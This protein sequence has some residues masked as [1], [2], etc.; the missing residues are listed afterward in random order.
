[1]MSAVNSKGWE[2][3]EEVSNLLWSLK[4]ESD[5]EKRRAII[6]EC[7]RLFQAQEGRFEPKPPRYDEVFAKGVEWLDG[8]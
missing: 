4:E 3:N 7:I 1:M 2:F 6:R 5:P 8:Q